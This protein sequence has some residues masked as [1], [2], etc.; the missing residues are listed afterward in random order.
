MP[1]KVGSSDKVISSN[2]K[3]LMH[4]GHSQKQSIAIAYSQAGRSNKKVKK[5]SDWPD[6]DNP[7]IMNLEPRLA[8][9]SKDDDAHVEIDDRFTLY[10]HCLGDGRYTGWIYWVNG[11]IPA[12]T[13]TNA[14]LQEIVRQAYEDG[15]LSSITE[16]SRYNTASVE[17]LNESLIDVTASIPATIAKDVDQTSPLKDLTAPSLECEAV[18]TL[19][20]VEVMAE[21]IEGIVKELRPSHYTVDTDGNS[22]QITLIKSK[23]KIMKKSEEI[24]TPPVIAATEAS[25]F[26]DKPFQI[27]P[28]SNING[29]VGY[30]KVSDIVTEVYLAKEQTRV[31]D[32]T[33]LT[34]TKT[35]AAPQPEPKVNESSNASYQSVVGA[36]YL[37]SQFTDKP[38]KMLP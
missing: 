26:N 32:L 31:N 23:E 9:M 14:T 34:P 29:D 2:I 8:G 16:G 27:W 13:Y 37:H 36:L 22:T 38:D 24:P 6:S 17:A 21:S 25:I 4:A 30:G 20:R 19:D 28:S 7:Y 35:E 3:E 18:P 12:M 1:L 5:S 11:S 33:K 10:V 15:L